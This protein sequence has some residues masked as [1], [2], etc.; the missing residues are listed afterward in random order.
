MVVRCLVTIEDVVAF[1][2]FHIMESPAARSQR[3]RNLALVLMVW[4]LLILASLTPVAPP[5]GVSILI[6]LWVT[7]MYGFVLTFGRGW[8]IGREVR[9]SYAVG[10]NLGVIGEHEFE[11]KESGLV[12]KTAVNETTQ[13]WNGIERIEETENHVFFYISSVTAFI[14]PKGAVAE[15]NADQFVV[16][17]RESWVNSRGTDSYAVEA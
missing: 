17:A 5:R 1:S 14:L 10:S 8:I 12:E 2:H 6:V 4:A 11:V 9:N 15:G 13:S 16:L 3:V 7:Y